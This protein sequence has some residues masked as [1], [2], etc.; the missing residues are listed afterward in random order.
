M[1]AEF[2][3]FPATQPADG[4]IFNVEGS[5]FDVETDFVPSV[6]TSFEIG[7]VAI[8]VI[9]DVEPVFDPSVSTSVEMGGVII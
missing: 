3:A 2:G 9:F 4:S 6:S 5:I 8:S 7:G 1:L